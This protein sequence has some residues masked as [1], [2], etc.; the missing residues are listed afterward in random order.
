MIRSYA[1]AATAALIGFGMTAPVA[2]QSLP[3]ET[4][5]T[6]PAALA[7][8]AAADGHRHMQGPGLQR[9][10]YR[11]QSR[12]HPHGFDRRRR[13]RQAQLRDRPP[14]GLYGSKLEGFDHGLQ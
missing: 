5:K 6:L 14:K 4:H 8:E 1:L 7:V 9:G 10:C 3:S 2:A 11:H 12:R 13:L